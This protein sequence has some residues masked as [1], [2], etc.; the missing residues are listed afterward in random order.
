MILK[1]IFTSEK[2]SWIMSRIHGSNTKIDLIIK[3][4]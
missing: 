4:F 1:D 2:R 3:Q